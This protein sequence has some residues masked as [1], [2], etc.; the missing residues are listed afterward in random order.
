M[1][2]CSVHIYTTGGV[3]ASQTQAAG[4]LADETVGGLLPPITAGK[5]WTGLDAV[6]QKLSYGEQS[7]CH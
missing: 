2:R 3:R 7:A 4:G 1:W 5:R 6:W